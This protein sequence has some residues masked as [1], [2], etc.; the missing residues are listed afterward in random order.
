MRFHRLD[1]RITVQRQVS[2]RDETGDE[3]IEWEDYYSCW[4]SVEPLRGSEQWLQVQE[5]ATQAIRVVVHWSDD[6]AAI[7]PAMRI[8]YGSKYLDIHS[9][10]NMDEADIEGQM[11]CTWRQLPE[12]Y[13]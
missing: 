4:A 13:P 6:V 2:S 7:T 10:L 8:K 3:L 12:S 5:T 1:K 11:M 9:V